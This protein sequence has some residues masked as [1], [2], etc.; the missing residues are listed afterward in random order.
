MNAE[1]EEGLWAETEWEKKVDATNVV[2]EVIN[3][4]IALEVPQDLDLDQVHI[5]LEV[6]PEV[7]T[8]AIEEVEI[9][10]AVIVSTEI[11]QAEAL[12]LVVI[13][14]VE[15]VEAEVVRA[16]LILIADQN[17]KVVKVHP[18]EI[19]LDLTRELLDLLQMVQE[20]KVKKN[21]MEPKMVIS[22]NKKQL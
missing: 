20:I 10:E 7:E 21:L 4:V 14:E 2:R 16:D 5:L 15:K 19:N 6:L 12:L 3:S 13:E 9:E 8:D 11:A 22:R 17:L 18:V 1:R